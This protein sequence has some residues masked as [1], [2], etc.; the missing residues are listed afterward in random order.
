MF[1]ILYFVPLRFKSITLEPE[2]YCV[3]SRIWSREEESGSRFVSFGLLRW[4]CS[5]VV[6]ELQA[7]PECLVYRSRHGW[8]AI[9]AVAKSLL[10]KRSLSLSLFLFFVLIAGCSFFHHC[11]QWFSMIA[12]CVQ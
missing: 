1:C 10:G 2:H 11:S 9:A 3:W 12:L 5:T 4:H 6:P 8:L 7:S